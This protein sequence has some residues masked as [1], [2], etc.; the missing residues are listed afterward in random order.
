MGGTYFSWDNRFDRFHGIK[1]LNK[2]AERRMMIFLRI[3]LP[4]EKLGLRKR[5]GVIREKNGGKDQFL[6]LLS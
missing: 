4:L 3:A 2:G 5:L 6:K 1:Y